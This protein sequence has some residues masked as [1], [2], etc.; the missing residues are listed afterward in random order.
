MTS[1]TAPGTALPAFIDLKDSE[2]Q[3]VEKERQRKFLLQIQRHASYNQKSYKLILNKCFFTNKRGLAGGAN[4]VFGRSGYPIP[5]RRADYVHRI[6]TG[7]PD[8]WTVCDK[9]PGLVGYK[10][11]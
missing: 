6:T 4:T 2:D 7:P 5:T 1:A 8:I 10:C 3:D 9:S 11:S